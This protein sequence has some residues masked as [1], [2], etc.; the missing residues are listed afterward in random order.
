MLEV[1]KVLYYLRE[2]TNKPVMTDG[3]SVLLFNAGA[4]YVKVKMD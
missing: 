4:H 3:N 1:P 2:V